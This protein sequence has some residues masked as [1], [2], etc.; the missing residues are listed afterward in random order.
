MAEP[1]RGGRAAFLCVDL[2]PDFL[3]PDERSSLYR[4]TMR[5]ILSGGLKAA[6]LPAE[7]PET[8]S[9]LAS[10]RNIEALYREKPDGYAYEIVSQVFH[11]WACLHPR[12]LRLCGASADASDERLRI[13]LTYLQENYTSPVTLDGLAARAGISRGECCRYFRRMTGQ[14][15]FQYL[16]QYRVRR[17]LR[18]LEET[19]RSI[20]DIAQ[21][22]GFSAQSYYT[23]CFRNLLDTTPGRYRAAKRAESSDLCSGGGMQE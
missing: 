17:S 20:A 4:E 10:L 8:A 12:L 11:A 6:A 5:P 16:T 3:C 1:A 18:L 15:P 21:D 22:C 23:Y 9:A 19:D 14:T 2:R 13:M 7:D